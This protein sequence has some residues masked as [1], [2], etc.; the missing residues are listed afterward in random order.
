[1]PWRTTAW[2]LH[3]DG[4][5]FAEALRPGVVGASFR[6][7]TPIP[8]DGT[9]PGSGH[10]KRRISDQVTTYDVA[11]TEQ[12]AGAMGDRALVHQAHQLAYTAT[13]ATTLLGRPGAPADLTDAGYAELA[14][15]AFS[16]LTDVVGW[17]ARSGTQTRDAAHFYVPSTFTDPFGSTTT[18]TWHTSY[19]VPASVTDP[20]GN[21]TSA[22]YDARTLQPTELTDPNGDR[23][24]V[25]Y[26]RLRRVELG[27]PSH[28]LDRGGGSSLLQGQ[29][30]SIRAHRPGA[31]VKIVTQTLHVLSAIA[32]P[33][34]IGMAVLH[35]WLHFP[36]ARGVLAGGSDSGFVV[37]CAPPWLSLSLVAGSLLLALMA[38]RVE[39]GAPLSVSLTDPVFSSSR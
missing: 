3:R 38:N 7:A 6:S 22:T 4:E 28:R 33:G 34:G 15:G 39:A 1:V 35:V 27:D 20:L 19:L 12:T 5:D 24:V 31:K 30:D 37:A 29:L 11:G 10:W 2:H 14:G 17:W 32:L 25:A 13:Q 18:V 16:S 23:T 21:V 8:W 9:P 36:G 26:Y